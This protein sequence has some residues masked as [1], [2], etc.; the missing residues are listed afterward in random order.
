MVWQR[1]GVMI[2][3]QNLPFVD[4]H[5]VEIAA[6]RDVVWIAL[7]R[8]VDASL[9]VGARSPVARL[10]GSEP[11]RGFRVESQVVNSH[12]SLTGSHRFARYLLVFDLA[13]GAGEEETLLSARTYA[14]FPGPHGQVYRYL[15]IRSKVHVLVTKHML[16]AVRRLARA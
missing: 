4:E 11:P 12:I 13:A 7:R 2:E 16:R 3:H 5:Q 15:V 8:Y 10:L 1:K 9:G 6:P 14:R